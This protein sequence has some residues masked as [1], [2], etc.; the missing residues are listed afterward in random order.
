MMIFLFMLLVPIL[1]FWYYYPKCAEDREYRN[2]SKF[3]VWVR[4]P[5]NPFDAGYSLEVSNRIDYNLTIYSAF[6]V[7]IKTSTFLWRWLFYFTYLNDVD[8]YYYNRI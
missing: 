4:N 7:G 1:Y 6:L 5:L 2:T 8:K 3:V